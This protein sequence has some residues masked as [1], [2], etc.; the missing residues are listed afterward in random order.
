[1]LLTR[2][3]GVPAPRLFMPPSAAYMRAAS[4]SSRR[5]AP[6]NI[7]GNKFARPG[8]VRKLAPPTGSTQRRTPRAQPRAPD[9]RHPRRTHLAPEA[10]RVAD[11]SS[12]TRST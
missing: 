3:W 4:S 9:T 10:A 5:I 2:G 1:M 8:S 6:Q 11:P 12:W 7:T